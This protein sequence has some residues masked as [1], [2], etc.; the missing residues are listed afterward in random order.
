MLSLVC[1]SIWGERMVYSLERMEGLGDIN[2]MCHE[3]TPSD[4]IAKGIAPNSYESYCRDFDM[5]YFNQD[6][7]GLRGPSGRDDLANIKAQNANLMRLY[8]WTSN[9]NGGM[10]LRNH[11]PYLDRCLE[12]GLGTMVPFAN[13]NVTIPPADA[14]NTAQS[15]LVDL[16][17]NGKLR[18]AVKAW[19]VTNEFDYVGFNPEEDYWSRRGCS[20]RRSQER[21]KDSQIQKNRN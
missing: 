21:H 12:L 13:Y 6:F 18:P 15:F 14:Q 20:R 8:N 2:G 4:V 11:K 19:Q 3:P 5:D 10:P 17:K 9:T 7:A 1:H 16:A